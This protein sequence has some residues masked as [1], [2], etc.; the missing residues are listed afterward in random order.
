MQIADLGDV[1]LHYR[2]DGD[3]GGA[4]IVFANSLGTDLR[5]WDAVVER[6]PAGLRIIRYD[7]RGHGLSSCPPAPYSMGA[8]CG[9][10]SGCWTIWTCATVC[11]WACRSAA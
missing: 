8:L 4:P 1:Q 2:V 10:R 5:V 9:M 11:S 7:K 3:A 6:L